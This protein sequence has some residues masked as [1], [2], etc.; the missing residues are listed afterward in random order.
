[1]KAKKKKIYIT[2]VSGFIG[3]QLAKTFT[4]QG[5]QVV[6][7]VR[8][9]T[10][11]ISKDLKISVIQSDLNDRSILNL[12]PAEAIIHC[13]T[14]NDIVSKNIAEGLSLSVVGTGKLL[15]AAKNAGINNIIFFSTAQVYG[16][17]LNGYYDEST[18]IN[19]QTSYAVNH[20]FGEQLCKFYCEVYKFNIC[21]LRPSNIYGVPQIKTVK[22]NTLV[23][24]C[25]IQE[26]I[27]NNSIT[28]NSS[29]KQ[30]RNFISLIHLG[31]LVLNLMKKLPKGF[32]T[33][34][35]CSNFNLSILEVAKI[36]SKQYENIY[37]KKLKIN[38]KSN[39]PEKA[40]NFKL[41]SKFKKDYNTKKFHYKMM[42]KEIKKIFVYFKK[43]KIIKK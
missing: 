13:A 3:S 17:E 9:L 38:V 18:K 19:C 16:T 2:G 29:G 24:M 15:E 32:S 4:K 20:Y 23:P 1:L 36:V 41:K 37:K 30:T 10:D 31:D 5:Y 7:I 34:N 28:L 43:S 11:I 35:C 22:R 12:K 40:N 14:A 21:I 27:N 33:R 8:N 39:K 25:F 42:F 6:G 26:A